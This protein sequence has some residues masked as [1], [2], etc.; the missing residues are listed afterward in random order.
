MDFTNLKHYRIP[1]CIPKS[2]QYCA[3]F[4]QTPYTFYITFIECRHFYPKF[5]VGFPGRR[6]Q[7]TWQNLSLSV[8]QYFL[9][10]MFVILWLNMS[11]TPLQVLWEPL[12]TI[13]EQR[14]LWY[15]E[16]VLG[17]VFSLCL[18]WS[19]LVKMDFQMQVLRLTG[20]DNLI[21]VEKSQWTI[22]FPSGL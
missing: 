14:W 6:C 10:V 12:Q 1:Y 20:L 9:L 4:A 2:H 8:S 15:E 18:Q 13:E 19:A 16:E 22:H 3:V 11:W 21:S 17:G 5:M 7:T